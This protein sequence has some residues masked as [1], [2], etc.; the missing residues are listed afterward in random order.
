MLLSMSHVNWQHRALAASLMLIGAAGWL[1]EQSSTRVT[2]RELYFLIWVSD[3]CFFLV[4]G[5]CHSNRLLLQ[6]KQV[7]HRSDCYSCCAHKCQSFFCGV[8]CGG[9]CFWLIRTATQ[10]IVR[11][12][13]GWQTWHDAS[14]YHGLVLLASCE[15]HFG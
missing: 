7:Q 14:C 1:V 11:V 13:T 4:Y 2:C 10:I 6:H 8:L 5:T 12:D 3:S 15:M 9:V